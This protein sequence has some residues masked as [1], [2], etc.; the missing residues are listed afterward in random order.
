M[1]NTPH[2]SVLLQEVLEAFAP[3]KLFTFFEGTVGAG[4][5]AAA[6]LKEHREVKRYIACDQDENA[7]FLAK[8]RLKDEKVVFI[9][10]NFSSLKET[11]QELGVKQVDGFFL[12]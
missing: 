10:D 5:H 7:L 9:H 4:G 3:L 2:V 8:E 11:L 12:T 6:L 1:S